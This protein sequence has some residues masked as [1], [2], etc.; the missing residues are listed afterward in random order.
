M[1]YWKRPIY[2]NG[3][4]LSDRFERKVRTTLP[5]VMKQ[6]TL[7]ILRI[8][9]LKSLNENMVEGLNTLGHDKFEYRYLNQP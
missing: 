5:L 6:G 9:S 1:E 8:I 7:V 4:A 3:D 2:I